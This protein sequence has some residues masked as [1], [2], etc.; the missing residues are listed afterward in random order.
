MSVIKEISV[1]G[2]VYDI[3]ANNTGV[4]ILDF[5]W[6][7]SESTDINWLRA[8]TF[9]WQDGTVYTNAYNHLISDISGITAS[10][11]TV[12]SYTITY[13]QATDG[14]KIVLA[15]QQSTVEDIYNESGVAWYYILDT[16][17]TR[18]KLPRSGHGD[19]VEKYQNGLDWYR[20]YSDGWCVQGG[21]SS[22]DGW[23]TITLLRTFPNT[24]YAV[25]LTGASTSRGG[26]QVAHI[27]SDASTMTTSS[28]YVS[29]YSL[30]T[31]N[32]GIY[33]QAS[34]Y[35]TS[36]PK[37]SG[38]K[39][40]Y[41]YVGQFSKSATEQTAGLNASLFNNKVDLDAGNLSSAGK[42]TI[43]GLPMPSSK[44]DDLTLGASGTDYAAPANGWFVF[45]KKSGG[46]AQYIRLTCYPSQIQC[47]SR[48]DSGKDLAV[49]MPISSG[50]TVVADYTASGTTDFFRFVYAKGDE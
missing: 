15:N 30:N 6:R 5:K 43:S 31:T 47:V 21:F 29:G 22:G 1:G 50:K 3:F 41:F 8:D 45:R 18:F 10:T 38:Y 20:I 2:T 46:S 25:Q 24:A 35:I 7:D 23:R 40:L 44:Y 11:E 4:D 13:Y 39:Y 32:G 37:N 16:G 33:W 49:F 17:N 27:S 36:Y 14:H 34:G 19:I 9:S 28:M 42:S 48:G 26:S 12:G